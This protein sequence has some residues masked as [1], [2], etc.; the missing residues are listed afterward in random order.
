MN[1][2]TQPDTATR[3]RIVARTAN[4]LTKQEETYQ[5][6]TDLMLSAITGKTATTA[7]IGTPILTDGLFDEL[8]ANELLANDT[9]GDEMP[10][11]HDA[12]AVADAVMGASQ[13][14]LLRGKPGTGKTYHA[15]NSALPDGQKVY[16]I[17]MTEETPAAEIRGHY[18]LQGGD[19]V[20]SD[21]P[22][23]SAWREGARLIINEIDRAS[24]DT[25]SLLYAIL[26]DPGHAQLT[27][28]TGETVKPAEGFQIIA[29]MNG[30]PEDLPE[31]LQDRLPVDIEITEIN[32]EAL[33]RLPKDLREPAASSAVQ[34]GDQKTISIRM[35][36]EF[37]SLREKLPAVVGDDA[38]EIAAKAVF[39]DVYKDALNALTIAETASEPQ[40]MDGTPV[41][42]ADTRFLNELREVY[43]L[44][45]LTMGPG[46]FNDQRVT[47]LWQTHKESQTLYVRHRWDRDINETIFERPDGT[48]IT[49]NSLM[50]QTQPK[51]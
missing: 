6:I 40:A 34:K 39:G 10:E 51:S 50:Q 7:T 2:E 46:P 5:R 37:A 30:Q 36:L 3:T 32:P 20:W 26:D 1:A 42:P 29:T 38:V 15:V 19:Y 22:A 44:D 13:R 33:M 31:A 11:K 25:L 18:V 12:W 49:L 8:L 35:W 14:V 45:F 9:T 24:E 27:L 17:T 28:P 43:S 4:T 23:V 21:G 16:S 41:T 47:S 48:R